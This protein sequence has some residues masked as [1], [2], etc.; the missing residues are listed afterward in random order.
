MTIRYIN[1]S[2]RRSEVSVGE[3]GNYRFNW[4]SEISAWRTDIWKI[5]PNRRISY[6][7]KLL[8]NAR[9][10]YVSS[11]KR[12]DGTSEFISIATDVRWRYTSVKTFGDVC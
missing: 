7:Y 8:R 12:W 9:A 1:A 10:I 3:D 6:D 2:K 5:K 11:D 4:I